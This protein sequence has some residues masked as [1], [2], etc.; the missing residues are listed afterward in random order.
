MSMSL[1]NEIYSLIAGAVFLLSGIAKAIDISVFQNAIVQ[2]GFANLQ[3]VAPLIVLA[4]VAVARSKIATYQRL[5]ANGIRV[6]A[7][8]NCRRISGR[9][10]MAA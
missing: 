3:F 8:S 6:P 5:A 1:R 7:S 9:L 10:S 4:E 2:Y